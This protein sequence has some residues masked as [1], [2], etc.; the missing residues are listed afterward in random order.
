[1][2]QID[3]GHTAQVLANVAVL[4]GI[5]FLAVEINQNHR[6]IEEQNTL[7]LLSARDAALEGF[8][9]MRSQLLE[10][11]ELLRVAMA[12]RAGEELTPFESRQAELLCQNRIWMQVSLF[13]RTRALGISEQMESI[14]ITARRDNSRSK[15]SE[16][17]WANARAGIEAQ[18][19]GDFV[20][21]VDNPYTEQ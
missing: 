9:S 15:Y 11:P 3:V 4:A 21:M 12:A 16:E 20:N 6:A 2:K 13:A 7:N 19:Y 8:N 1:M 5:V 10:N 14:V 17:C 18:G